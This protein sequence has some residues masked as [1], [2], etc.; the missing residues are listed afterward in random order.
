MNIGIINY[1]AGNAKSVQNAL[2]KLKIASTFVSSEEEF[3]DCTHLILPG[4]GSAAATMESLDA[5]NL[6]RPLQHTVLV[7]KRPFLGICIGLQV[8]F[9]HSQEGDTVCFGWLKGRVEKF[10]ETSIKV[11]QI[12]WNKVVFSDPNHPLVS[13]IENDYF[14]FVNSYYV[15][16]HKEDII[17]GSTDYGHN[18]CASIIK[19]NIFATQFHVEKSGAAGLTILENFSKWN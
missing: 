10:D 11:P 17:F 8:L 13:G 1:K 16:P 2:N 3:K 4:V 14:Y 6:L 19:E 12:G 9:E 18:F 5:S 7:E 15:I